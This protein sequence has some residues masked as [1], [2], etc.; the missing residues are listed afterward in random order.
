MAKSSANKEVN[1]KFL[2]KNKLSKI[3][4]L[5]L[6]FISFILFF[7]FLSYVFTFRM[8]QS[9]AINGWDTVKETEF[10]QIQNWLNKI[11][12]YF[13]YL[14]VDVLF[15]LSAFVIPTALFMMSLN[16]IFQRKFFNTL[17]LVFYPFLAI[18]ILSSF[19][20]FF[21][22][23]FLQNRYFPLGGQFGSQLTGSESVL[24][25]YTGLL[26]VFLTWAVLS[27]MAL[28]WFANLNFNYIKSWFI[29]GE[30]PTDIDLFEKEIEETEEK[31]FS[32]TIFEQENIDIPKEEEKEGLTLDINEPTPE[33]EIPAAPPVQPS[34]VPSSVEKS[35]DQL[36]LEIKETKEEKVAT[37]IPT[38][39]EV[40]GQE[41]YD[42]KKD[43]PNYKYPILEL[44]EDHGSGKKE[45]NRA[46]L[47]QNK[48]KII[49]TLKNFNIEI[50]SI[51]A[52]IGP[53]VTLYEITPA[54][55]VRVSTIE[56]L[57]SDIALSLAALGIRIIAPIPGRGTIGI[58]VPNKNS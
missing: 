52:T 44:L 45:I 39:T 55:G 9:I 46:E 23:L 58:E 19:L 2:K 47:E 4:G 5:G 3:M 37:S 8:D 49:E 50:S 21:Q 20:A 16:L 6:L 31:E 22:L 57:D 51:K 14:F 7:S 35:D 33:P 24:Y 43:L 27:L 56:R 48:N 41:P 38:R 30:R 18:F 11:G 25:Q 15:G 12:V 40:N 29:R 10:Y 53:T 34:V 54:P 32:D 13:G 17:K 42:P 1:A 28:V 26:G 36:E